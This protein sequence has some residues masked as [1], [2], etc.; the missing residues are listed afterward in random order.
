M[1]LELQVALWFVGSLAAGIA[2]G[3]VVRRYL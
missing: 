1:S 3:Y 2:V